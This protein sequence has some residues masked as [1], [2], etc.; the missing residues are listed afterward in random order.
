MKKVMSLVVSLVLIVS[1]ALQTTFADIVPI[2]EAYTGSQQVQDDQKDYDSG[3]TTSSLSS[4]VSLLQLGADDTKGTC[5]DCEG[6]VSGIE[7]KEISDGTAPWDSDD[8][9]GNDSGSLNKRVRS[10]DTVNYTL[11]V[12]TES[13]DNKTL[14]QAYIKLEFA[15]PLSADKA[16]F[17]QS[18]MKW[19]CEDDGYKPELTSSPDGQVLT[20]YKYLNSDTEP[21]VPGSFTCTVSVKVKAMHNGATVQPTFSAA[22]KDAVWGTCT[23]HNAN[24]KATVTADGENTV[25]VSAAPRYNIN[26][27]QK[28]E[29]EI[30]YKDVF[31]FSTGDTTAQNYGDGY[32]TQNPKV[33]GRAIKLGAVLQIYNTPA[34]NN[35]PKGWKGIELPNGDDITFEIDVTSEARYSDKTEDITTEYKP[36]L[37]SCDK[38]ILTN[39]GKSN[40]DDRVLNDQYGGV[41]AIPYGLDYD[42]SGYSSVNSCYKSGNWSAT[43]SGTKITV[44]VSGYDIDMTKM[45]TKRGD[46]AEELYG[47]AKGIGCFSAGEI[48][49]VQPFNKRG[50]NS[51]K[52][53]G[54]DILQDYT[55]ELNIQTSFKATNMQV[56]YNSLYGGSLVSSTQTN[57]KD[58]YTTQSVPISNPGK[59]VNRVS[60]NTRYNPWK[61]VG[62]TS[63]TDG[64]DVATPGTEIS[65]TGGFSYKTDNEEEQRLYY[66]TSLVKFDG[67]AIELTGS[68]TNKFVDAGEE[69]DYPEVTVYYAAKPDGKNWTNDEELNSADEDYLK[70]YKTLDDLKND[71]KTCVGVLYCFKGPGAQ[72]AKDPYYYVMSNAKIKSNMNLCR[73]ETYMLSSFSR[74]WTKA[75][76]TADGR[77]LNNIPDWSDENTTLSD[78]PTEY[79]TNGST[80]D[81]TIYK[82]SVYNEDGTYDEHNSTWQHYGD[83]LLIVGYNTDI[84]KTLCQ[85]TNASEKTT[86]DLD[87]SQRYVDYKLQPSTNFGN[88]TPDS[89]LTTT[90][91]IID[92]LPNYL[93]YVPGSA[94]YGGTYT[95]ADANGGVRGTITGGESKEPVVTDNADGTQTLTWTLSNIAV[96]Q[97]IPTIYYSTLIGSLENSDDDIGKGQTTLTN[98]VRVYTPENTKGANAEKGIYALRNS[99]NS[100]G[101]YTINDTVKPNGTI[102]YKIYYNAFDNAVENAVLCD[103]MPRNEYLGND[104]SGSYSIK[105]WK[106]NTSA[107]SGEIN[108]L[109]LYYTTSISYAGK[110]MNDSSNPITL[111]NIQG[112]TEITIEENGTADFS[113]IT[114]VVAWAI[115]GPIPQGGK[116]DISLD[117][118][119]NQNIT[120]AQHTSYY[121]NTISNSSFKMQAKSVSKKHNFILTKNVC[122][123]KGEDVNDKDDAQYT[124]VLSRTDGAA[125]SDDERTYINTSSKTVTG[126]DNGNG[127]LTFTL[128]G[129]ETIKFIGLS[130]GVEYSVRETD[131]PA[132]VYKTSCSLSGTVKESDEFIFTP[133]G[134]SELEGEIKNYLYSLDVFIN[135]YDREIV[136]GKPSDIKESPTTYKKT[137]LGQECLDYIFNNST[138]SEEEVAK[139]FYSAYTKPRIEE[140]KST[141]NNVYSGKTNAVYVSSTTGDDGNDGTIN[142]PVKTLS[143]AYDKVQSGGVVCLKRG[144]EW[145]GET[146]KT[147]KSNVTFTAYDTGAKPIINGSRDNYAKL[148]YW[149]LAD[150]TDNIW[151]FVPPEGYDSAEAYWASTDLDV[152]AIVLTDKLGRETASY[153]CFFSTRNG[154]TTVNVTTGK[155]FTSYKDLDNLHFFHDTDKRGAIGINKDCELYLRCDAGN[156]GEVYKDIEILEGRHLFYA[157][158]A[159]AG[160]TIDNIEFRNCGGHGI[161]A[162]SIEDFTVKNC[163]FNW[164]GGSSQNATVRY[165]NGV[166]I[167]GQ[168]TNFTVDN[169]YFSQIYDT[170]ATFQYSNTAD[171]NTTDYPCKNIS[172]TNN[173][174][175]YC[176]YSIEYFLTVN[177]NGSRSDASTIENFKISGNHMWYAGYGLCEQRSDKGYDAHIKSWGHYNK[178]IGNF[179]IT[180]N[181][182]GIA[183]SYLTETRYNAA[184]SVEPVYNN[185][186]YIQYKYKNATEKYYLGESGYCNP[187]Y[188]WRSTVTFDDD[189]RSKISTN[190]KD[191]NAK[192]VWVDETLTEE[193]VAQYIYSTSTKPRIEEIKSTLN[194]EYTGTAYYVSYSTGNDNNAGTE[195]EP[196]KTISKVNSLLSNGTIKS[197]SVVYFKRGDEWR[198]ETLKINKSNVTFSAY[199]EGAKPIINGSRYNYAD[200]SYWIEVDSNNHI[201]KFVPPDNQTA[202]DYWNSTSYDVGAIVLTDESGNETASYKCFLDSSGK[203][204]TTGKAFTSYE[205]LDNLHF[206]HDKKISESICI[207]DNS[208]LYL[209]CDAGNPGEIYSDIEFLEGRHLFHATTGAANITV[210]NIEFRNCGGHGIAS[211]SIDG[212]TI[213]NCMFNWIGGST[214]SATA[215]Y[216]NGVQIY[217]QATNFTVDNCY[218]SQICGDAVIFGW[219]NSKGSANTNDYKFKNIYLTNNVIEYCKNSVEY[220]FTV[221]KN[222]ETSP[223]D[224]STIENFTISGNHMWY[225]GYG[226]CEQRF[227]QGSDAHIQSWGYYNKC[228]GSFNITDNIFGVAKS[229]LTV[230]RHSATE[231]VE[232]VYNNNTYIQ[233][234]NSTSTE[235]HYLGSS[236][237][238]ESSNGWTSTVQFN[239]TVRSTIST[240]LS[241][242]EAKVVWIDEDGAKVNDQKA[243]PIKNMILETGVSFADSS[244]GNAL[245]EYGIWT[246]QKDA[247]AGIAKIATSQSD[248]N[249]YVNLVYQQYAKNGYDYQYHPNRYGVPTNEEWVTYT[250]ADISSNTD[251]E[252]STNKIEAACNVGEVSVWMFN[253]PMQYTVD[254]YQA[255][256]FSDL[257]EISDG[258]YI[259]D[260]AKEDNHKTIKAYYNQRLGDAI[261]DEADYSQATAH[262]AAYGLKSYVGEKLETAV[263]IANG[264]DTLKFAY[265]AFDSEGKNI[266]STDIL[267]NY[268]ITKDRKLYAVYTSDGTVNSGTPGLTATINNPDVYFNSDG[269]SITRLNTVMNPYNCPNNDT[270]IKNIAISYIIPEDNTKIVETIPENPVE[271][272]NYVLLSELRDAIKN[273]LVYV[274]ENPGESSYVVRNFG[275]SVEGNQT[276]TA[277][278]KGNYFVFFVDG[279]DLSEDDL[280]SGKDVSLTNKNRVEFVTNFKTSALAN[281]EMFAFVSMYYDKTDDKENN[282]EWIVSD[283]Y[284]DYKFDTNGKFVEEV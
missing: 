155:K 18:A 239:D 167:Y 233:F 35:T 255:K 166:Q 145:R 4:K 232:P 177:V 156:P 134:D 279:H 28:N 69:V 15:L 253:T 274:D 196:F 77:D 132:Y 215:R 240:N 154:D 278:K 130:D 157:Y 206:F 252:S 82:K 268:R 104:Y 13:Y 126:E 94:F 149:E 99:A 16:E 228:S 183:R 122:N 109:K 3:L 223:S 110:T 197:G 161:T 211:G 32:F 60:Y 270:N 57:E 194:N 123:I 106:L 251:Y 73:N 143:K 241:D 258:K 151:R 275:S 84:T 96:G 225:A 224:D 113:G 20:C 12:T 111:E 265:W 108:N 50:E 150:G 120:E 8:E 52:T 248:S 33:Y 174:M 21:V 29:T 245:D 114:D 31:D 236:G 142:S 202:K 260:D 264:D 129:G 89:D 216:G 34:A 95:Q 74:L 39:Y 153:K 218:F 88:Y 209:R 43:Q 11:N 272:V 205:D 83:S 66:A 201:Y 163:V 62:T 38:N 97:A 61:G 148:S 100:Y 200:A 51:S 263:S 102:G 179:N 256:N 235:K 128:K 250:Y 213:E 267:Y 257:K 181:I 87:A 193:E 98:K 65:I 266:A 127:S 178:C 140:I 249:E 180:D 173:V 182:F 55:N 141:P 19:M 204:K 164:I 214:Q 203:N 219:S 125:L 146:V 14:Y 189:V 41:N 137:Y 45:P 222:G 72:S 176:Q 147:S 159:A 160:T 68:H 175:E 22:F 284:I 234:K 135:Y 195:A 76:W 1:I 7:V 226:F 117:I 44:K 243:D 90:V 67:N 238:C 261:D 247:A 244:Y 26:F 168:A 10:Y 121:V 282:G 131:K 281:R 220:S 271:G 191:S 199:D 231:S 185:N 70:F 58:D 48:W 227:D 75:K 188:L 24:E 47:E 103:T 49:I 184:E 186:T 2:I 138:L 85:T 230:T 242:A 9:D 37:Y 187:S 59:F 115:V 46:K 25:T 262:L 210:D 124:F 56:P 190:L 107:Y 78:F 165:G 119:L 23:K 92:T 71:S 273:T 171:S 217:G 158:T 192:I 276:L 254:A 36:L 64:Q 53:T 42:Q 6:R 237:V 208:E 40:S 283:N 27:N 172:F 152:G 17:D 63:Y 118:Q 79:L 101:K 269:E 207:S 81:S 229:Y 221:Y 259:A 169:C 133:D 139:Y 198:G 136:N 280:L 162:Q 30:A 246:S 86:Y 91:T 212:F 54:F 277:I 170:A 116:I 112:W 93:T 5:D 105:S 80:S 144:D